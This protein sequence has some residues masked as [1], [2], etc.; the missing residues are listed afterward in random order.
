MKTII[1]ASGRRETVMVKRSESADAQ[2]I[3]SLIS[4]E[5]QAVFG[6]VNVI[7]LLSCWVSE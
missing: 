6:R 1:S 2:K 3:D 4:P 5:A 7:R